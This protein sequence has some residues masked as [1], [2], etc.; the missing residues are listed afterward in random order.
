MK[1]KYRK[2]VD[3]ILSGVK[4]LFYE[5]EEISEK[6]DSFQTFQNTA[7]KIFHGLHVAIKNFVEII[8]I[9]FYTIFPV[10]FFLD[11][12]HAEKLHSDD[13]LFAF[14]FVSI[15]ILMFSLSFYFYVHYTIMARLLALLII[16]ILTFNT[17]YQPERYNWKDY[18]LKIEK[19]KNKTM[20]TGPDEN[21]LFKQY[22]K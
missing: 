14:I 12:F 10:P 22:R 21:F 7:K 17:L 16:V 3:N 13:I 8:T 19:V 20:N 11:Y 9:L 1:I 15:L 6:D 18:I 2:I 4:G 5:D